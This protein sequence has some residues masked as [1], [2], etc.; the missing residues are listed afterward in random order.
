MIIGGGEI[1]SASVLFVYARARGRRLASSAAS[2]PG[3]YKVGLFR[4]LRLNAAPRL[5]YRT[6][7]AINVCQM[8]ILF[9]LLF[10]AC[11][12]FAPKRGKTCFSPLIQNNCIHIHPPP[13]AYAYTSALQSPPQDTASLT[14]SLSQQ[15]PLSTTRATPLDIPIAVVLL[16]T[17]MAQQYT[18]YLSLSVGGCVDHV[19]FFSRVL[20]ARIYIT[21]GVAAASSALHRAPVRVI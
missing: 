11:I 9:I 14:L 5:L 4:A 3:E 2:R 19:S 7:P 16:L 17:H 10:P 1:L 18:H 13:P 12:I 21:R 6:R 8:L 20:S 15:H